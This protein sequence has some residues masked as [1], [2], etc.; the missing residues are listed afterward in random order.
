MADQQ[1]ANKR[2]GWKK[3]T[4]KRGG[5]SQWDGRQERRRNRPLRKEGGS[6]AKKRIEKKTREGRAKLPVLAWASG[7]KVEVKVDSSQG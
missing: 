3:Q 1:F 2:G 7:D 4:K 5:S 6:W